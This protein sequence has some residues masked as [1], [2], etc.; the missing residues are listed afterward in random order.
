MAT[1]TVLRS[2]SMQSQTQAQSPSRSRSSVLVP[3]MH[4]GSLQ[5][6][7]LTDFGQ[8]PQR[9]PSA[10]MVDP[11]VDVD[12][13]YSTSSPGPTDS[14]AVLAY[15]QRIPSPS[16]APVHTPSSPNHSRYASLPP[17]AAPPNP[18][19][20]PTASL[21]T[22]PTPTP[23]SGGPRHPSA[24][25][26]A[27]QVAGVPN[28][29]QPSRPR[30]AYAQAPSYPAITP[31]P[32][33]LQ[34]LIASESPNQ[35]QQ[36]QQ[37]MAPPPQPRPKPQEEV[38]V[39]CMMRDRDMA[40]V[41]VTS[42]G[43]WSRPSDAD[44]EDLVR[45]DRE[46]DLGSDTRSSLAHERRSIAGNSSSSGHASRRVRARGGRLTEEGIRKWILMVRTPSWSFL[47][48]SV[49]SSTFVCFSQ[50]PSTG[51]WWLFFGTWPYCPRQ[52]P[53]CASSLRFSS[54]Y[55]TVSSHSSTRRC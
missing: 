48:H 33:S 9:R 49:T 43:V 14:P 17:G 40:D 4:L 24:A 38:C 32:L 53:A 41:D 51:E 46:E 5:D 21:P 39:E 15:D 10:R 34:G 11:P 2:P 16:P 19:S 35:Q 29:T 8:Q 13:L 7:T 47:G 12:V 44:Y 37:N 28:P 25:Q 42:P 52:S 55:R 1:T 6:L 50:M 22:P 18:G 23:S 20:S 45:R 36:P 3:E 26:Q 30:Q 31:L 27:G 54:I